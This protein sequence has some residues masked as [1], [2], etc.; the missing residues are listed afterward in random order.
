MELLTLDE[1]GRVQL[2]SKLLKQ[3]GLN[4][5]SQLMAEIQEGKLIIQ[6]LPKEPEV[7]HEGAV[8]VVK[9]EPIGNLETFIDELRE[10]RIT[11]LTA[12]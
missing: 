8:L 6:P 4:R 2:P 5:A 12:W 9:S 3:L 7:Y 10:E 11:E 1:F